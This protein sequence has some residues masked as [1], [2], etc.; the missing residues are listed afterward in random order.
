MSE[1]AGPKLQLPPT[2]QLQD[3][4]NQLTNQW[5]E[6]EGNKLACLSIL[7]F[8]NQ[9]P[10][11]E[12]TTLLGNSLF[13][14]WFLE[15]EQ[16]NM[17]PWAVLRKPQHFI[18]KRWAE[19]NKS[20]SSSSTSSTRLHQFMTRL[21]ACSPDKGAPFP[22]DQL[23]KYSCRTFLRG[24]G[25][26]LQEFDHKH[27]KEVYIDDNKEHVWKMSSQHHNCHSIYT[28]TITTTTAGVCIHYQLLNRWH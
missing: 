13:C 2:T 11:A 5:F 9:T 25:L 19:F 17:F 12:L 7:A 23:I 20:G 16:K 22:Q 28:T 21:A 3:S 18:H 1:A 4:F 24:L 8:H 14:K 26:W 15:K 6:V 27:F 10:D